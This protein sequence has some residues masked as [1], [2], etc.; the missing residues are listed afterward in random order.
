MSPSPRSLLRGVS[1]L[2]ERDQRLLVALFGAI[3]PAAEGLDQSGADVD[4]RRFFE[5]ITTTTSS[6]FVPGLAAMLVLVRGLIFVRHRRPFEALSRDEQLAFVEALG[7]DERY[8]VRQ[9]ATT[10]K[11]LACMAYFD[12]PSVRIRFEEPA[13]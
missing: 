1:R 7:S 3:I 4:H 10:L 11:M 9:V 8:P 5:A 2:A 13:R 6:S 12:D